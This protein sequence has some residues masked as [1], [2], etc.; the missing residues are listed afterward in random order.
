MAFEVAFVV[1]TFVA[2]GLFIAYI[3]L[4]K[5]YTVVSKERDNLSAKME[6][7]DEDLPAITRDIQAATAEPMKKMMEELRNHIETLTIQNTTQYQYV[8][9]TTSDLAKNTKMISDILTSSQKRGQYAEM[10]VERILQMAG[11]EKGKHY[12]VQYAMGTKRPDF[13]VHLPDDRDI[14]IDSK[15]PLDALQKSID[16]SDEAARSRY[17]D[18]HIKA[19]RGHIK[20]LSSKKYWEEGYCF[21]FG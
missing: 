5:K 14:I 12:D 17:M 15:A 3:R 11:F 20:S 4:Q 16:T 19:V 1:M 18:E 7:R 13:I 8:K 2:A 9:D 10:T 21:Q 6:I